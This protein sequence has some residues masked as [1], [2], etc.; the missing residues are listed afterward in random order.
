VRSDA[1][2]DPYSAPPNPHTRVY[3]VRVEGDFLRA[4]VTSDGSFSVISSFTNAGIWWSALG[5][6]DV[7]DFLLHTSV[8]YIE[9]SLLHKRHDSKVC[10]REIRGMLKKMWPALCDA[11]RADFART[12]NWEPPSG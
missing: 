10:K 5:K 11:I 9:N 1:V 8:D 3:D 4:I 2:V 7:R 6:T 12:P